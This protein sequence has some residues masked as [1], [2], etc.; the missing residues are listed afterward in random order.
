MLSRQEFVSI[1]V[2]VIDEDVFTPVYRKR[3]VGGAIHGWHARLEAYFWPTP[4]TSIDAAQSE[5]RPL[6]ERGQQL[7][8]TRNSWT[9]DMCSDAVSWATAVLKWGGVPQKNVTADV[10]RAVIDAAISRDPGVAPM[11][12]GWTKV[13]AFA[14]AHLESQRGANAIW[15]SRV[16]WSIV[17]RA[18][19]ILSEAGIRSIPPW[20]S[21]VGKVPGRGGTRWSQK[22][23]LPWPLAYRRWSSHFA[24]TDL[25]HDIRDELNRRGLA[26]LSRLR[27][28][29][30]PW[31]TRSVEMVL[32]MD[33]Y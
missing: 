23:N 3:L 13:A 30:D 6:L 21:E 20:L 29:V 12:S 33:G 11:N 4:E 7:A 1:L 24:A 10:V 31:T 28:T 26:K 27:G 9:N 15:D 16:S 8:E 14:T 5:L 19:R 25:I 2:N 18:D 17:R 32:F 22:L